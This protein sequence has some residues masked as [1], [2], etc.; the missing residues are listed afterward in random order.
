MLTEYLDKI[1]FKKVE[2]DNSYLL[3]VSNYN[4]DISKDF[5]DLN[6]DMIFINKCNFKNNLLYK[7]NIF[8]SG[9]RKIS[10]FKIEC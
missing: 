5:N 8:I 9:E 4:D 7:N 3:A 1:N 10:L 6:K 2:I